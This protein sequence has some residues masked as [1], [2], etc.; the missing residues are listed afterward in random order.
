MTDLAFNINS[1]KVR[2]KLSEMDK[3]L[4]SFKVE[5]NITIS[6]PTGEFTYSANDLWFECCNWDV[7][8]ERIASITDKDDAIILNSMSEEF[9]LKLSVNDI[10][11]MIKEMSFYGFPTQLNHTR[12]ITRDD[13]GIMKNAFL[14]FDRWW[15]N[16]VTPSRE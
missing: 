5:M 1:L 15:Q 3:V 16:D 4:P 14:D 9:I 6:H 13:F 7:F 12:G 10:S 11:I 8:T 2:M